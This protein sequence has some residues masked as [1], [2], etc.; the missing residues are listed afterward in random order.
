MHQ[1]VTMRYR[2]QLLRAIIVEIIA[3]YDQSSRDI[4][5]KIHWRGGQHS[6]LHVP[7]PRSGEHG[8]RTT[9]EA[10]AV[11]VT[12]ATRWSD[13][14]IAATLNRMGLPTGQVDCKPSQLFT[15]RTRN[16]RISIGREERRVAH[17][18]GSR[19]ETRRL[20]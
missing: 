5:L 3:D 19:H 14:D 4:V 6:E 18:V 17:H 13:E 20:K 10:V 11:I 15:S 7:K 9:D 2:R 1:G 12:M 8:C 16:K